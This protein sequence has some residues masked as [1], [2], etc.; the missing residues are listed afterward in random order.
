MVKTIQKGGKG[1]TLSPSELISN[2]T[3][4]QSSLTDKAGSNFSGCTP[5]T[6]ADQ[7]IDINNKQTA[8]SLSGGGNVTNVEIDCPSV[9]GQNPIQQDSTCGLFKTGA[10]LDI[11]GSSVGG[12]SRKRKSN[13]KRK[14]NKKRKSNKRRNSYKKRKSNKRRKSITKRKSNKKRKTYKK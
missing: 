1:N 13:K 5:A 11:L 8:L 4:L 3:N 9:V 7:R 10:E 14:F 12:G 6:C 2:I